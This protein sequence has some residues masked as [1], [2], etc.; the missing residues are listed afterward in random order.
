M[1]LRSLA[2]C[3][4][5]LGSVALFGKVAG[6]QQPTVAV[7]PS[8]RRA[9]VRVHVVGALGRDLVLQQR[10]ASWFDPAA[11]QVKVQGVGWLDP[12]DILTP[13]A[14]ALVQ[15][16]VTRRSDK[17]ARLYF[18]SAESG[19]VRYL[20]RDLELER[21]LDEVAAEE[22]AQT[23]HLS[24]LALLDGQ[25]E[26]SRDVVE[27]ALK[28]DHV[29]APLR[30]AAPATP[31][32]TKRNGLKSAIWRLSPALGYAVDFRGDEGI[33]H[34]PRLRL[35]AD[36]SSG[37]GLW[38]RLQAALPHRT[39]LAQLELELWGGSFLLAPSFRQPLA[40]R[41]LLCGYAG[42]SLEL[43]HYSARA[44]PGVAF[45][46]GPASNELRPR[47]VLGAFLAFGSS[48]RFGLVAELGL[49]LARSRYESERAGERHVVAEASRV[50]PS[51]GLELEL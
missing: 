2:L 17:L 38:S 12:R 39:E 34:G 43:L 24:T 19:T 5:A 11:L 6:A 36:S 31:A 16:W 42:A 35:R 28:A 46:P 47:A 22:L 21:G 23:V 20:L 18:A 40:T 3:V 51:V 44:R 14:G 50:T 49:A 30:A 26:T 45:Y 1:S 48:P 13:R 15:V 41:W 4:G 27:Q 10:I 8:E 32:K 7:E 33:G 37:F 9:T 29:A 25:L